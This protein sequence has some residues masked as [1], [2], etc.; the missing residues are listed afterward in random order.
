MQAPPEEE[1]EPEEELEEEPLEEELPEEDPP[2]EDPPE[3]DP[4]EEDPPEEDPPEEEPP[5]EELDEVEDEQISL[6]ASIDE[7]NKLETGCVSIRT[8]LTGTEVLGKEII[9][10]LLLEQRVVSVTVIG[11]P[12]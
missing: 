11:F 1:V 7:Y 5:E 12:I 9:R 10:S 8:L 2:E 3:E 6:T 4:P